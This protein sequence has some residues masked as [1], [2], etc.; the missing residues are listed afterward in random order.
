MKSVLNTDVFD[1]IKSQ[2]TGCVATVRNAGKTQRAYTSTLRVFDKTHL[3]FADVDSLQAARTIK[4][5]PEVIV[6]VIDSF[7]GRG[8][9]FRGKARVIPPNNDAKEYFS[10]F[11]RWGMKNVHA[12]VKDFIL[13]KVDAQESVNTAL[14]NT[15]STEPE[16]VNHL[17]YNLNNPWKF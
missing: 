15:D 16:P 3:I 11:E 14:N 17:T 9:R 4:H 2:N 8:Q 12:R 7:S 6:E 1:F 13:I 10:F 5:E